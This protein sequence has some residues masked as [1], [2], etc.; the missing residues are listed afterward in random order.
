MTETTSTL[1]LGQQLKYARESLNIS[2]E[3]AAKQTNLKRS[4]IDSLE[5]DIFILANVPPTFVR[6]Y[7]RNYVRFLRLPEELISSVNYGEVTIPKQAKR[8]L[9]PIKVTNNHK[10]QTRWVKILTWLVL[11]SAIGM[12]LAWWWQDHQKTQNG[13]E[14]LVNES[15]QLSE[16]SDS[17]VSLPLPTTSSSSESNS[18]DLSNVSPAITS[19]KNNAVSEA[20]TA[21]S[22]AEIPNSAVNATGTVVESSPVEQASSIT[23]VAITTTE[24]TSTSQENMNEAVTSVTTEESTTPVNILQQI[25][26]VESTAEETT[27]VTPAVINNDE[28]RIEVI[29]AQ[30][31]LTVR[32][33]NNKKLAEKLY[34][35]GDI[36]T[37]NDNEN[38]RLTVGA[39]INV[40]IYYKGQEVPMQLDGRVARFRLPL[41]N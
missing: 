16:N 4:H 28:L 7:V 26:P 39:P 1:S 37:F 6:G 13:D 24:N 18:I 32:D 2:I 30:S 21:S 25:A 11:L 9:K 14:Q 34:N 33:G 40:K 5:N 20:T 27:E 41:A 31:W 8:P 12:T 3:E 36:L 23:A 38:Y 35:P 15:I 29:N 17:A 22:S 19:E 10:S